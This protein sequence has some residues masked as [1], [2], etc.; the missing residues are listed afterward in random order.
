MCNA[1]KLLEEIL[2]RVEDGELPDA[3]ETEGQW[4]SFITTA[5]QSSKSQVGDISG[6]AISSDDA[7]KNSRVSR[8]SR[9]KAEGHSVAGEVTRSASRHK[10]KLAP[11]DE[12][13]Y[14]PTSGK[15]EGRRDS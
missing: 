15:R 5:T 4:S 8:D 14:F 11:V 3:A 7:L 13:E 1:E 6:S 9:Q 2:A 10:R 12:G